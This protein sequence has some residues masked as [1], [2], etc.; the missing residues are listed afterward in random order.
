MKAWITAAALVTLATASFSASADKGVSFL[1]F[2]DIPYNNM[3]FKAVSKIGQKTRGQ[4]Y[5]FAIH[6]GDTKKSSVKCTDEVLA[7][8]Q[9]LYFSVV[10]GPVFF[11]PGDNDWT[12]CDRQG[13]DELDILDNHLMPLYFSPAKLPENNHDIGGWKVKRQEGRIENAMWRKG[14]VQFS[15]VHI[16]ATG[17]GREEIEQSDVT[18]ALDRVDKRDADNLRWLGDTFRH[19]RSADALVITVHADLTVGDESLPACSPQQQTNCHPYKAF[20]VALEAAASAYQ[21]PVLIVHG[22]TKP[23]CHEQGYLGVEKMQRLNG[24]GDKIKPA[25]TGVTYTGGKFSFEHIG[26][27]SGPKAN[28]PVKG[29]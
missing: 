27:G 6:Y 23:Y 11:T 8:H 7:R 10:D 26:K 4:N 2:G 12:D 17:N 21:K 14:G 25:V 5:P 13:D 15:T 3:E 9:K 20:T 24:P 1:V 28:C 18:E 22:D 16:V 29:E 19:A